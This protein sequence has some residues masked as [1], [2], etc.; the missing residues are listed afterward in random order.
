MNSHQVLRAELL[1]AQQAAP[2]LL[3]VRLN[4]LFH[5][6]LQGLCDV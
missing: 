3:A 2:A 5:E 6:A 4:V 1:L